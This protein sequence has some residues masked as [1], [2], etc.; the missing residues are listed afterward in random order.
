MW[1]NGESGISADS[2]HAGINN[3][4][5]T[6]SENC[7][8]TANVELD[9]PP[10]LVILYDDMPTSCFGGDDGQLE[11][12]ILGGVP[13]M[14]GYS[15]QWENGSQN[16]V[17]SNLEA[18][19]YC[20][21]VTDDNNCSTSRCIQLPDAEEIQIQSNIQMPFCAGDETGMI[22]VLPQGGT[23]DYSY[24]WSGPN[25]FSA[26][27]DSVDGLISGLYYLT[28]TDNGVIDCE[29][30][31]EIELEDGS[32]I[33]AIINIESSLDCYG[34]DDAVLRAES[35]GGTKPFD[36]TWS[37]NAVQVQNELASQLG[38]DTYSVTITDADGCTSE[39][40]IQLEYPPEITF[41]FNTIDNI[42]YGDSIGSANALI[43]G[44]TGNPEDYKLL[45]NNGSSDNQIINLTAGIYSLT[46]TDEAGCTSSRDIEIFQ[47]AEPIEL[48]LDVFNVSCNASQDGRIDV[49]QSGVVPPIEYSLNNISWQSNNSF[50][51]LSPGSYH[52]FIRDNNNCTHSDSVVIEQTPNLIVNAGDNLLVEF[53]GSVTLN[54]T[55]Q[56][57]TGDVDWEWSSSN[58]NNF[59]CPVGCPNPT[60]RDITKSFS[61]KVTA[62][63]SK[64]CSGEDF[65]TV[66]VYEED[67]LFVPKAFSPNQ[68]GVNDI[69]IVFGNPKIHIL[70]F[71]IYSRWGE[72]LFHDSDFFA[73]DRTRGWN[74]YLG[75]E[76][77]N[78]GT[79]VW[80]AEY[81]LLS[82]K[83]DFTRGQTTLLK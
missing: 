33:E 66:N 12:E 80:T 59:S 35:P 30:V 62:V 27:T 31:F 47:P 17:R 9:S 40:S 7:S 45:W 26:T 61:A 77:V 50:V 14:Q 16:P 34:I 68:D 72:L 5:V 74:G 79:Y 25:A 75:G 71:K 65:V 82:G 43:Q 67:H 49:F 10:A 83:I 60:I 22:S 21:T 6:D 29:K 36:Y 37:D 78:Q 54:A 56:N 32:E 51:Q 18:G 55:V 52:V 24:E 15:I 63:D 81:Q 58:I 57:H 1:D 38:P 53:G 8:V 4:T 42:C 64:N 2:L 3:V 73:N 69:L 44:G 70:N 19:T 46:V 76:V 39:Q 23:G 11:V 41:E 13:G 20:L 28:I 48:D